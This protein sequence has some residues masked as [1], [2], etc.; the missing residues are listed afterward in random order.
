MYFITRN[1][2]RILNTSMCL[3]LESKTLDPGLNLRYFQHWMHP[4]LA[5][6]LLKYTTNNAYTQKNRL[7]IIISDKIMT[8]NFYE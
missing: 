7:I 5:W 8:C 1:I 3:T 2:C 4:G 6:K